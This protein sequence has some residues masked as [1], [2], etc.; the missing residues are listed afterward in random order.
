MKKNVFLPENRFFEISGDISIGVTY[1]FLGAQWE[2]FHGSIG[3]NI[4]YRSSPH[5]QRKKVVSEKTLLLR[6]TG[7]AVTWSWELQGSLGVWDLEPK[8]FGSTIFT[9]NF[10]GRWTHFD[11]HILQM[12]WFNHQ[13]QLESLSGSMVVNDP[14]LSMKEQKSTS[15][16]S[17]LSY[18]RYVLLP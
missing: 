9:P 17:S 12:G 13:G 6:W 2:T 3:R 18:S 16:S 4:P 10:C 8:Y 5:V 14:I 7:R 15:Q 11:E 1:Q